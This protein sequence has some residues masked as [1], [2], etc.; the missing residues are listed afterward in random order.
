MMDLG[1]L[2]IRLVIGLTF[3]AHGTQKLFG[4]FGGYGLKG[5]GGWLDSIGVKPGV[6]MALLAGLGELVGGLLFAAGVGTWIGAILIA[7][8]MLIAIVKVHGQN[9]YWA[10][11]NGYEYNLALIAVAIGVALIG[12]GAYVLF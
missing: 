8:T 7:F 5:T 10:T 6:L 11:S 4:W 1:L 9:G 3:A 2:I 12:P